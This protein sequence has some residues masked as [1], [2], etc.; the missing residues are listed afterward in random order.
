MKRVYCWMLACF[1]WGIAIFAEAADQSHGF[2]SCGNLENGWNRMNTLEKCFAAVVIPPGY[3]VG[4]CTKSVA[5]LFA[6]QRRF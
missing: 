2:W 1:I 6:G 3:V 5:W 4:I